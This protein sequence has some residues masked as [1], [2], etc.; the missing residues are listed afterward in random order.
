MV[1]K[2][3]LL[4]QLR[5]IINPHDKAARDQLYVFLACL[6]IAAFIWLLMS[7]SRD[8][9]TT[10]DY[11]LRI[12]GLPSDKILVNKPED[13]LLLRVRGQGFDLASLD[14]FSLSR[15]VEIDAKAM[16]ISKQ[17]NLFMGYLITAP[18]VANIAKQ[19]NLTDDLTDVSPDTLYFKFEEKAF[20]KVPVVPDI[21]F[22]LARQHWLQDEVFAQPDSIILSGL[23]SILDT[24]YSVRTSFMDFG[25]LM[26]SIS[27]LMPIVKEHSHYPL[28]YSDDSV[29]LRIPVEQFTEYSIEIPVK[30][31]LADTS[32][33][34]RFFPETVT[35]SCQVAFSDFKKLDAHL[36]GVDAVL[37]SPENVHSEYARIEL[38]RSP[39]FVKNISIRPDMVEYLVIQ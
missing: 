1:N 20:K 3:D 11:K 6:A 21:E 25:V 17:G 24:I 12:S 36:F 29:L 27:K 8:Y 5:R 26:D 7:L 15:E 4:Q 14:L 18:Y 22:K 13:H 33:R 9:Y 23:S 34:V 28:V 2:A 10:V 16:K 37:R 31:N 39:S 19:L 38:L 35:L 32:L 30:A